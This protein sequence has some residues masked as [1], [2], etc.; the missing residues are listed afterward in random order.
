[1]VED[2]DSRNGTFVDGSRVTAHELSD[3]ERLQL[4]SSI[5][6][7]FAMTADDE[8]HLQR[9]LYESSVRD[10]L[11]G[12]FNRKH[13]NERLAAEVAYAVRHKTELALLMFDLDH[14]KAIN[15]QFGH[16]AGD[17]VLIGVA[18][19]VLRTIRLEDVL[20]RYGGE[21]FVVLVRGTDVR[22]AV[23]LAER[24][25]SIVETARIVHEDLPIP[26]KVSVG[27]AT[28]ACCQG[29]SSGERLI[30]VADQR[31]Y[32]AKQQGRNRVVGP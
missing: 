8:E 13:M 16:Q 15:D 20:C 11:T 31:L 18:G 29:E 4:G 12:I 32:A 27:V 21:E 10:P 30:G 6:M 7:R 5:E 1:V 23:A 9:K 22:G 26:V 24:I 28:I 25:R 17:K 3:G 14:F 19:I 2:L